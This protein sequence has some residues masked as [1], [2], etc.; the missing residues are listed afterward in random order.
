MDEHRVGLT[1]VIRR[2]WALKGHRPTIRVQHRYE[3]LYLFGFL[4]PSSENTHW[5]LLPTINVDVFTIALQHFATSVGAGKGKHRQ[6]LMQG[7]V[8]EA[9]G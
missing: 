3:W 2:V 1:P 8:G 7:W 9:A 6:F 4:S 5:L